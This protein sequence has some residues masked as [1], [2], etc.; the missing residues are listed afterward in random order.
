MKREKKA[1]KAF[2][3]DDSEGSSKPSSVDSTQNKKEIRMLYQRRN[4]LI[5]GPLNPQTLPNPSLGSDS[6]EYEEGLDS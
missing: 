2:W 5:P 1:T 4:S 6:Q 3:L